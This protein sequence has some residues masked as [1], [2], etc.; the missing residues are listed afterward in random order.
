MATPSRE[1]TSIAGGS[2]RRALERRDLLT[3]WAL[4]LPA[5]LVLVGLM[6]LPMLLMALMSWLEPG[7]FGGVRWGHYTP[8]AYIKFLF[9]RNLDDSLSLNTDYLSI[10]SRS[11]G[12]AFITML[13]TLLIGFPVSL[14]I[15]LQTPRRR[16]WLIF[17]VT[18][19]FWTN[20]LVRT[21]AWILLLRN[22][23][24]IES[25]LKQMG[26]LQ[27]SLDLLYTPIAVQI[28]LVYAF[29][30]FMVLPIYTS[31]EKLDWRLLEAA[32]DLYANRWKALWRVVLPLA[33]PGVI[34]GCILVFVPALGTYYIPELLGGAKSLMIGN[35]IQ[36]QFGASRDWPFGAALSFA[37]LA[38]VLLFML[39]YALRFRGKGS[40]L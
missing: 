2:A 33:A 4:I 38:L 11:F 35:L 13:I 10:F 6:L 26:L 21:Y 14:Y 5:G 20:L 9:D 3:R 22:G 39:I 17:L 18:I 23:G 32:F 7:S 31:L 12:L 27:G 34:A 36:Q 37:L 19:P 40:L 25:G 16:Q 1:V 24:L 28:G 30:P 8:E 29:L 15:A